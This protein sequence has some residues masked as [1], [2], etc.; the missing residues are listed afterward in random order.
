MEADIDLPSGVDGIYCPDTEAA[1]EEFQQENDLDEFSDI[2]MT[3]MDFDGDGSE[4][5]VVFVSAEVEDKPNLMFAGLFF[6]ENEKLSSFAVTDVFGN[7]YLDEVT[8]TMYTLTDE[9]TEVE[10]VGAT[11]VDL[12]DYQLEVQVAFKDAIN[13]ANATGRSLAITGCPSGDI[14]CNNEEFV[15]PSEKMPWHFTVIS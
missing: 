6:K 7:L 5:E 14:L 4:N 2:Y 9:G 3:E 8:L 12:E 10:E 11:N 1:V 13:E 15:A